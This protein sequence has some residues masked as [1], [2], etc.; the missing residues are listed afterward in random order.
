M[1]NLY[2]ASEEESPSVIWAPPEQHKADTDRIKPCTTAFQDSAVP[3]PEEDAMQ[4]EC[5]DWQAS[6]SH[7][8][9][10]RKPLCL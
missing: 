7:G 8:H 4:P 6:R 2:T 1:Q 3:S 10:L 5:L 9:A